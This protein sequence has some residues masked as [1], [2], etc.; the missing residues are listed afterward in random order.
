MDFLLASVQDTSAEVRQAAAYGCG[1]MAQFGGSEYAPA[2][3]KALPLLA[4]VIANGES[5]EKSNITST[6]N[7]VSAV[8]KICKYNNSM[9]NVN[10][11][12]PNWLTWLPVTEDH[13]EAP[14]VY[15]YLC[16]LMEA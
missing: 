4:Q 7:C 14:H 11:I 9:V 8:S 16:E 12:I 5:R 1:V 6:E 13:E 3:A 15:G 2:C 10:E